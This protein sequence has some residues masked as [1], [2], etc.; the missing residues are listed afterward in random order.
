M[1][2]SL[3]IFG[4]LNTLAYS[5][6]ALW[7]IPFF[8]VTAF[9]VTILSASTAKQALF[10]GFL[11]GLGWFGVGISWVHVAIADFGGLPIVASMFVMFLLVVYLSLFPALFGWLTYRF[12]A[13]KFNY[14]SSFVWLSIPFLWLIVEYARSVFLTGF[15]WL[16]I[17]YTQIEGPLRSLAPII[18]EFGLQ[19]VVLL[20]CSSLAMLVINAFP[21]IRY[22][23][24]VN[25]SSHGH[26][27]V[28]EQQQEQQTQ[29]Q[30]TLT[31]NLHNPLFSRQAFIYLTPA[32]LLAL[33]AFGAK[34]IKWL[35]DESNENKKVKVALVQ[36]NIAQSIKWQPENEW[37]TMQAYLSLSKSFF[38]DHDVIIWPEAAIPRL[39]VLSVDYLK[40]LDE[41]SAATDTALITGIVDYQ[42]DTTN[43][44]NNIVVLGK[45]HTEDSIGHYQYGHNNRFNKHHLL[46]IGE[47]VPFESVLRKIAPLFD[48]PMSSFSRGHFQQDNLVAN[49]LNLSPAIC[50]EIAFAGQVR[51]NLYDSSDII[52]TLS[53]DA[54]FGASHGPW[55]HLQ[56]AQMRALEFAKPVIR[57][58]N[59]GVTAVIDANGYIQAQLPQFEQAVLSHTVSIAE[60]STVYKQYGNLL[61]WL[62]TLL[63]VSVAL[64]AQ[65][66]A[67]A[68]LLGKQN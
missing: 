39:E 38:S 9:V 37:P 52:L 56:I 1:V 44:Y 32:L 29:Q 25:K 12:S 7:W 68:S 8:T 49:G 23:L 27:Q 11:F 62:F 51:A 30:N 57:V 43:A 46:P 40:E 22:Y 15:P 35:S 3:P 45:K 24:K 33:C 4:A 20:I 5:P 17:G 50:F 28:Q 61:T 67:R 34:Q 10:R 2:L 63:L 18:G 66:R 58:T 42:V 64:G 21:A 14:Q 47:F 6:F 65:W 59:N 36:G 54:W 31:N 19:A 26:L 48:L 41:L 55:Q 16:S 53:N 13:I 60:S